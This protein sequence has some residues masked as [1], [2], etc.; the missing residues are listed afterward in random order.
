MFRRLARRLTHRVVFHHRFSPCVL[1]FEEAEMPFAYVACERCFY[2]D[3]S[4]P[5][6]VYAAMGNEV[7]RVVATDLKEGATVQ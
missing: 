1:I 5:L 4:E 6:G 2:H 3:P 7:V